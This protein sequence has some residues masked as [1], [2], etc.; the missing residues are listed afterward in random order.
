MIAILD[1]IHRRRSV[2]D[3]GVEPIAK[4]TI[5]ELID[6]ATWAPSAINE[7]PWLFTVVDDQGLLDRI[8]RDAKAHMLATAADLIPNRLKESLRDP[9]FHIFYHA[10]ALIVI[11]AQAVG[12]WSVEDC[13]LAAQ[14]LM[15][16]A[17]AAELGTCWIGF[18]QGWL[19]TPAGKKALGLPAESR[20]V[21]PIIIG[22]PK[23][24][25]T[26]VPR[27]AARINWISATQAAAGL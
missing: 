11:S 18:A 26:P 25:P 20:P 16:A 2:R 12:P 24:A 27:R 3:Y 9:D 1:V 13:A 5:R 8:S 21:A 17:S 19:Q 10:P 7:Q 15:L 14:N 6:A 4:A 23:S 22:Y